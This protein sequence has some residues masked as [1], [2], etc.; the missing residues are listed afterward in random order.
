MTINNQLQYPEP[1]D[2]TELLADYSK[3]WV[4][5][6]FDEKEVLKSGNTYDDIMDYS[7]KGIV[8]LVPDYSIPIVP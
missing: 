8:L 3:K 6:S 2:F 4:V 1:L 5:L 7:D